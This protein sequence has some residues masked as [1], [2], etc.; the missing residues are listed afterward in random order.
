[1]SLFIRKHPSPQ[2]LLAKSYADTAPE[3]Y[4]PSTEADAASWVAEQLAAGWVPV[5]PEPAPVF[6]EPLR[7]DS[8]TVLSRLTAAERE[9]LFTARRTV[10]Q[11]DYFLTR[12]ATTGIVSTADPDLPA[13]QAM[14]AQLGIVAADRWPALLAP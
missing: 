4:E 10:W 5:H 8:D 6:A 7:I 11:V 12:A 2:T 13:A 1:M 9:A 3:G 14:L